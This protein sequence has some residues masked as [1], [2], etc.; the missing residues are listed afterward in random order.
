MG[1]SNFSTNQLLSA[2][3]KRAYS[4]YQAQTVDYQHLEAATTTT[5]FVS[6][7]REYSS[8]AL[9]AEEYSLNKQN[10]VESNYDPFLKSVGQTVWVDLLTDL[11]GENA[12]D[13]LG[14]QFSFSGDGTKL[15]VLAGTEISV[16]EF[17]ATSVE[18]STLSLP[19]TSTYAY[20]SGGADVITG[21]AESVNHV[22]AMLTRTVGGTTFASLQRF[23]STLTTAGVYYPDVWSGTQA[24]SV[25]CSSDG[26]RVA[27][28]FPDQGFRIY[29]YDSNGQLSPGYYVIDGTET[30]T[31]TVTV[32]SVG[33][34]RY[35]VDGVDR[36]TLTFKRGSV[37]VFDMS[38]E[39]NFGHPLAFS[40]AFDGASSSYTQGVVDNYGT[41]PP[42][43]PGSSVTFTVPSDAPSQLYYYCTVHGQNMGS[44][45]ASTVTSPLHGGAMSRNGLRVVTMDGTYDVPAAAPTQPTSLQRLAAVPRVNVQKVLCLTSDGNVMVAKMTGSLYVLVWTGVY[46][47]QTV[48]F[49]TNEVADITVDAKYV[50]IAGN[51]NITFFRFNDDGSYEQYG[52]ALTHGAQSVSLNQNGDRAIVGE[53]STGSSHVYVFENGR[54]LRMRNAALNIN[55]GCARVSNDGQKFVTASDYAIRISQGSTQVS[56][57]SSGWKR[58]GDTFPIAAE[59]LSLSD[60]GAYLI[61]GFTD[62]L[63]LDIDGEA[64]TTFRVYSFAGDQWSQHGPDMTYPGLRDSVVEMSPDGTRFAVS[65]AANDTVRVFNNAFAAEGR[66]KNI[67]ETLPVTLQKSTFGVS[68]DGSR[69]IVNDSV[70][71][72]LVE[73]TGGNFGD[74][75]HL[76]KSGDSLAVGDSETVSM[77]SLNSQGV[78]SQV[79]GR[80]LPTDSETFSG[81]ILRQ[82][83]A[84]AGATV[85]VN[86]AAGGVLNLSTTLAGTTE[87]T[88]L[89]YDSSA[90]TLTSTREIAVDDAE[91]T[92]FNTTGGV[93][94]SR[95]GARLVMYDDQAIK[96]YSNGPAWTLLRTITGNGHFVAL[97]PDG[98]LMAFNTSGN[99]E[100]ET[101]DTGT[102]SGLW[103]FPVTGVFAFRDNDTIADMQGRV[104]RIWNYN[105]SNWVQAS[106]TFQVGL[107]GP[108]Y[109][110][111][112]D[113]PSSFTRMAWSGDGTR[114]AA[115]DYGLINLYHDDQT[116]LSFPSF[117]FDQT[118]ITH[119]ANL[120][121]VSGDGTVK[122]IGTST[123]VQIFEK[124]TNW[125]STATYTVSGAATSID[126]SN[127]GTR[128]LVG[129]TS[130]MFVLT[131]ASGSWAQ[132]GS[133]VIGAVANVA[134]SGNGSVI[135]SDDGSA[136]KSF[137]LSSGTWVT[138]IADLT[139]LAGGRLIPSH[140]GTKI[141][142]SKS[143]ASGIFLRYLVTFPESSSPVQVG[144]TVTG[145]KQAVSGDGNFKIVGD[146]TDNASTGSVKIFQKSSGTWSATPNLTLTGSSVGDEFGR[147]VGISDDGS[148]AI[149]GST[150]ETVV[151]NVGTGQSRF[152]VTGNADI[153]QTSGD[154]SIT[155]IYSQGVMKSYVESLS[156]AGVYGAHR[157]DVIQTMTGIKAS[158]DGS[159]LAIS[160]PGDCKVLIDTPVTQ[161]YDFVPSGSTVTT[162]DEIAISG[163]ASVR[164]I[165][166]KTWSSSTGEVEIYEKD[167]NG[168]WL[169]SPT[170][171][172][173]GAATGEEFGRAL[174]IS[175]NGSRIV[176]G[177]ATKMMVVTNVSGS[178]AQLGSDIPGSVSLVAI[179]G[180]GTKIFSE[181]T[182]DLRSYQLVGGNW[183]K[184]VA[185]FEG[186][187]SDIYPLT[188]IVA[189]NDGDSLAL[190]KPDQNRIVKKVTYM[191]GSGSFFSQHGPTIIASKQAVSAE[192]KVIATSTSVEIYKNPTI[193]VPIPYEPRLNQTN[194]QVYTWPSTAAHTISEIATSV[195]ISANGSRVV[196]GTAT[197]M[198]VIEY[199]SSYFVQLGSDIIGATET[200]A[201]SKDG[202]KVMSSNG[203][204]SQLK[205][206]EY[207]SGSW[208]TY[209]PDLA[210]NATS[211]DTIIASTDGEII[212]FTSRGQTSHQV[213]SRQFLDLYQIDFVDS[214]SGMTEQAVSGDGLVKVVGDPSYS[215][216][217]GRIEIYEKVGVAWPTIPDATFQGASIDAGFGFSLAVSED[218]TRI[219]VSSYATGA[220]TPKVVVI[221][222]SGSTWQQL[223][224]D[225]TGI[226][227]SKVAISG[228]GA[229]VFA[230]SPDEYLLKSYE[231]SG[232]TTWVTYLGGITADSDFSKF[233]V[234]T[235]GD[236]VAVPQQYTNSRIYSKQ[237][238]TN[239]FSIDQDYHYNTS[240]GEGKLSGNGAV[241]VYANTSQNQIEIYEKTGGSWG[242]SPAYT[243]FLYDPRVDVSHDGLRVLAYDHIGMNGYT[244]VFEKA[245]GVWSQL[246]GLIQGDGP[247]PAA[248]ISGDGTKILRYSDFRNLVES[249]ELSGG[250]WVTYLDDF[251]ASGVDDLRPSL[252]GDIVGL[253]IQNASRVFSKQPFALTPGYSFSLTNSIHSSS[254]FQP[255]QVISGTGVVKI[256]G[257]P[258]D[259]FNGS[260]SGKVDIYRFSSGTWGLEQTIYGQSYDNLGRRLAI[261]KDGSRAVLGGGGRLHVVDYTAGGSPLWS[262]VGS[263]I[264]D[265][266]YSLSI[267]GDNTVVYTHDAGYLRSYEYTGG[268]WQTYAQS[269]PL[270]SYDAKFVA[271]Y[272]GDFVLYAPEAG[273]TRVLKFSLTNSYNTTSRNTS[274][275]VFETK[276]S[277]DGLYEVRGNPSYYSGGGNY[278]RIQIS[279][280]D[281]NVNYW[282][283]GTHNVY[284]NSNSENNLGASVDISENG[285]VVFAGANLVRVIEKVAGSWVQVGSDIAVSG[286]VSFMKVGISGDGT[287]IYFFNGDSGNPLLKS[288]EYT[289]GSWVQYA[290]DIALP[291]ITRI[292]ATTTGD[293][294]ALSKQGDNRVYEIQT[295]TAPAG[296][297]SP[298]LPSLLGQTPYLR[299]GQSVD[300]SSDGNRVIIADADNVRVFDLNS[301]TWSQVGSDISHLQPGYESY[302]VSISGD[303]QYIAISNP[304]ENYNAGSVRFYHYDSYASDW[305]RTFEYLYNIEGAYLGKSIA[306]SADG[307]WAAFSI[308]FTN[309]SMRFGDVRIYRRNGNVW[310]YYSY[311]SPYDTSLSQQYK[312]SFGECIAIS[313]DG[314]RVVIGD[315]LY[316][317][318]NSSGVVAVLERN[319]SGYYQ[320]VG[321]VIYGSGYSGFG[322]RVSISSDGNQIVASTNN[323]N[324]VRAYEY[325]SGTWS[326]LGNDIVGAS[327]ERK[328]C[329][330]VRFSGDGNFLVI[331]SVNTST[332]TDIFDMYEKVVSANAPGGYDWSLLKSTTESEYTLRQF[333]V[334]IS[335]GTGTGNYNVFVSAPEVSHLVGYSRVGKVDVH[336]YSTGGAVTTWSQRGVALPGENIDMTNDGTRV[337]GT[338]QVSGEGSYTWNSFYYVYDGQAGTSVPWMTSNTLE[339]SLSGD[340]TRAF[341][342]G[343]NDYHR[344][345]Q[346]SGTEWLNSSYVVEFSLGREK[347]SS[348]TDGSV[349]SSTRYGTEKIINITTTTYRDYNSSRGTFQTSAK[350]AHMTEDASRVVAV[351]TS[352][353]SYAWNGV[354]YVFDG[355]PLT[356]PLEAPWAG[357]GVVHYKGNYGRWQRIVISRDGTRVIAVFEKDSTYDQEVHFF[358]KI[359]H[360]GGVEW[361]DAGV[362]NPIVTSYHTKRDLSM[363]TDGDVFG[364]RQDSDVKVYD[365]IYTPGGFADRYLS[366]STATFAGRTMD[367]SDDGS[368]VVTTA[369]S[370]GY[371]AWNGSDYSGGTPAP[372]VANAD[373]GSPPHRVAISGDGTKVLACFESDSVRLYEKPS[374]TWTQAA[375]KILRIDASS[376]NVDHVCI[377]TTGDALSI[378]APTGGHTIYTVTSF[379]GDAY[380]SR[381]TLSTGRILDMDNAGNRIISLDGSFS[382]N[383]SAY[384]SD[385]GSVPWY[386]HAYTD[387]ALSGD[388]TR[389]IAS[390]SF[391]KI[392]F[393]YRSGSSW[394]TGVSDFSTSLSPTKIS[395]NTDGSFFGFVDNGAYFHDIE[396]V[397][398]AY[399]PRGSPIQAI[400]VID[401]SNDG[402]RVYTINEQFQWEDSQGW[403]YPPGPL[404]PW[405]TTETESRVVH[406]ERSYSDQ[407]VVIVSNTSNV[408]RFRAWRKPS[409]SS[410]WSEIATE[411][412][413]KTLASGTLND[414]SIAEPFGQDK[415]I[416]AVQHGSEVE[417]FDLYPYFTNS[418]SGYDT[419]PIES[420]PYTLPGPMID[421][422]PTN[423]GTLDHAVIAQHATFRYNGSSYTSSRPQ[424]WDPPAPWSSYDL[425]QIS[426]DGLRVAAI[427]SQ[428]V[429]KF[430][431]RSFLD[432]FNW[433]DLHVNTLSQGSSATELTMNTDGTI[434]GFWRT[435]A[436]NEAVFYDIVFTPTTPTYVVVYGSRGYETDNIIDFSSDGRTVVTESGMWKSEDADG[437]YSSVS[438][439][440]SNW[441]GS[442]FDEVAISGDGNKVVARSTA[443]ELHIWEYQTDSYVQTGIAPLTT[444]DPKSDLS[445]DNTGALVGFA[446]TGSV[447]FYSFSPVTVTRF[448]YVPADL[449]ITPLIPSNFTYEWDVSSREWKV[450][451]L[452]PA[453]FSVEIDFTNFSEEYITGGPGSFPWANHT[454]I[455]TSQDL[456]KVY[457][458]DS[459]GT[460]KRFTDHGGQNWTMNTLAGVTNPSSVSINT[461]GELLGI[462]DN[463][464]AKFYTFSSTQTPVG[465]SLH[466][467]VT[468]D[469]NS[470]DM[471]N[472][473]D[474]LAVGDT[475]V[476]VYDYA[477]GWSLRSEI[478]PGFG[479]SVSISSDGNRIAAAGTAGVV[480]RDWDGSDW[481][482]SVFRRDPQLP[483][484]AFVEYV[485]IPL[486][487]D[488]VSSMMMSYDGTGFGIRTGSSG[489]AKRI[490]I[491][492]VPGEVG[493][494]NRRNSILTLSTGGSPTSLRSSS[495]GNIIAFGWLDS[496]TVRV[497]VY[498]LTSQL[499]SEIS[500]A[501]GSFSIDLTNAGTR[502]A[503][504]AGHV[505]RVFEYS[506]GAWSQV[507]S[508]M[509]F[510]ADEGST[511]RI[512]GGNG[513]YVALGMNAPADPKPF[514]VLR[515]YKYDL[516]AGQTDWRLVSPTMTVAKTPANLFGSSFA[517]TD[518][519]SRL[520]HGSVND[521]AVEFSNFSGG[522]DAQFVQPSHEISG[523]RVV[524]DSANVA[525]VGSSTD[526]TIS[527]Y[528]VNN[529]LVTSFTTPQ[530]FLKTPTGDQLI[531]SKP[532]SITNDGSKIVTVAPIGDVIVY[533]NQGGGVWSQ[534]GNTIPVTGDRVSSVDITNDGQRIIVGTVTETTF[535]S[536]TGKAQVFDLANGAWAQVGTDITTQGWEHRFANVVAISDTGRVVVSGQGAYN[537]GQPVGTL[538]SY[539]LDTEV[540]DLTFQ[541]P[542]IQLIG[543]SYVKIA[544]GDVY[545]ELGATISTQASVVPELKI[546]GEVQNR[547]A[548][549]YFL[550]YDCEDLLRKRATAIFRQVDVMEELKAL[551]L[552]GERVVYHTKDTVY[553]DAGVEDI[554]ATGYHVAPDSLVA[555]PGA[556]FTPSVV[557]DWTVVWSD[558]RIDKHL[559]AGTTVTRTV[560]VRAR[561]VLTLSGGSS[562]FHQLN[563]PYTDPGVS[564]DVGTVT[565]TRPNVQETGVNV[566]TYTAVDEFGIE[567]LPVTRTVNVKERPSIVAAQASFYNIISDPISVQ[568]PTVITPEGYASDLTPF[569]Q[570]SNNININVR[571]EYTIKHTLVESDG[572]SA[573]PLN[574]QF[575]V[576]SHGSL[577]R[578][579]SGTVFALSRNGGDLAVFDTTL[580][581]YKVQGFAQYG[582]VTVPAPVTSIKFTPD[583]QYMV[584]GMSSHL[585]IGLV[586]VYRKNAVFA[587]GWEQ[588]GFDLFGTD[589]LGKFGESVDI[590][591]DATRIAIGAPEA[592]TAISKTGS[593]KIYDWTGFSWQQ[594]SFVI[595]G[596][597][598]SQFLG[599]S[600]SLDNE[601]VTLAVGS[602]GHSRTTVSG[603]T[604]TTINVGKA[605]VYK[606]VGSDWQLSGSE[607]EDGTEEKRNG[608]SVS[609]SRNGKT[610]VVGSVLGG[611]VRVYTLGVDWTG[612]HVPGSFGE[613]V[614]LSSDGSTFVAGS[615]DE[616]KGRVYKYA[617]G[618]GGWSRSTDTFDTVVAGEGSTTMLGKSVSLDGSGELLCVSSNAD[619]RIYG[620]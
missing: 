265:Y 297:A 44:S 132:L 128:V 406:I 51:S 436:L 68:G 345:W 542:T 392:D 80:I 454:Q 38:D 90:T 307:M 397:S 597:I 607:I 363:D 264:Y 445:I 304:N 377:N 247:I 548:G 512:S 15:A 402:S 95:N 115:G 221:E 4:R 422:T 536:T 9:L 133:D 462:I 455:R 355:D 255:R 546:S 126:V 503:V 472:D 357:V 296:F 69:L 594:S 77:F 267:S 453:Q 456:T 235:N 541:A 231:L 500:A 464:Q 475:G 320:S 89:T 306:I 110:Y 75:F 601:G 526:Q 584:V 82:S 421:M 71:E 260:Y 39:S 183:T 97:S 302:R 84:G 243:S 295:S 458:V 123:D 1:R 36:P 150:V 113:V 415:F 200:V 603:A 380:L 171:T 139:L 528:D 156:Y 217:T 511:I 85:D 379:A 118:G 375:E 469:N 369:G 404:A 96:V 598:P 553:V 522:G 418:F 434:I 609:L 372:W 452:T 325:A 573:I 214:Y 313:E 444:A 612:T 166:D 348:N 583:A 529:S 367:M 138:Y 45:A 323:S 204:G 107:N 101:T 618:L 608:T 40:Q 446:T 362:S 393:W 510:V 407:V 599:F 322:T 413:F 142:V 361:S 346:W 172:F 145:S 41:N 108:G 257:H 146:P 130:K 162:V 563:D 400:G 186:A 180:D 461:D 287:K 450:S 271:S 73:T 524:L 447:K 332:S 298:A 535:S 219:V 595:E 487:S 273:D 352:Q 484:G 18:T 386:G 580:K 65:G 21:I 136:V 427:N 545:T 463:G 321:S 124:T 489:F 613:S 199:T 46:W 399:A 301:S 227:A 449:T 560:R 236:I 430:W 581:T 275:N 309:R 57:I 340:G 479:S 159:M 43:T 561:P 339:V 390:E 37:Y 233:S 334:A 425:F 30:V 207:T 448:E 574:Q 311:I 567:A 364:F 182:L 147:T 544:H 587:G 25:F 577:L 60:D 508:P 549:T 223:G 534:D 424:P 488:P 279:E 251:Y 329:Y 28:S 266:P 270:Y 263:Y 48:S 125:P 490:A 87:I 468:T 284:A 319:S 195:D 538:Q 423:V 473:G 98:S 194:M 261:S 14:R 520:I 502:L 228:D 7:R 288:Y 120:Q 100:I 470:F 248:A 174:G 206:Y 366:R 496:G 433:S 111:S 170:A 409:G 431:Y 239:A 555:V 286:Q 240:S 331:G 532:F 203:P 347:I 177:G 86:A 215:S 188:R 24:P 530:S 201:I 193:Q 588:V 308:P 103:V 99:L 114:L 106:L 56:Q 181:D 64:T 477:S 412:P 179:S 498:D 22:V 258:D 370:D 283:Q 429:I 76:S 384:A 26:K 521:G 349:I 205:S 499:G 391:D 276:I 328:G 226:K 216:S 471:S 405:S 81:L 417:L 410:S 476:R 202:T 611:G 190:S 514:N 168:N 327:G 157:P 492:T 343:P 467:S 143:T 443:D 79:G 459:S 435:G 592:G 525:V 149:V 310:S 34:N 385:S 381:S 23:D 359:T 585:T 358:Y 249:Y 208:V 102:S 282:N 579:V 134:I 13:D 210:V 173:T 277:G 299:F 478:V 356:Q 316:S 17:D 105:G 572:I 324:Y 604:V 167:V 63:T 505:A 537:G 564:V 163:D 6:N 570:S 558:Q 596:T 411:L 576:G 72:N 351:G 403:I 220:A 497:R 50:V 494:T 619:V 335:R 314:S 127:D 602:P 568:A 29:E 437:N 506:S 292:S 54:W 547:V 237:A 519:G 365:V 398:Y 211:D 135:F 281:V 615:K 589:Y 225:I 312:T 383:G 606:L 245:S 119:T 387:I 432:N 61:V 474:T 517:L 144:S 533:E 485:N 439:S 614:S 229:Y 47:K 482:D 269:L 590:N 242:T 480:V 20:P 420:S 507:G 209:L 224:Q 59:S 416:I 112:I 330:D 569:L 504:L 344:L 373:V 378:F 140:N 559:R 591:S 617:L 256:I 67:L 250:S 10:L 543:N 155:Y 376:V 66:V 164:V 368:I 94:L 197:K 117:S 451:T 552:I 152:T 244:Y 31:F 610:L 42:G 593:V 441:F 27:L 121:A 605:S 185:N 131:N 91:F 151:F 158:L 280:Y 78:V 274:D 518:D 600:V 291:D 353:G 571:G 408:L 2:L 350:D 566:L 486:I 557:G 12:G 290:P 371:Y 394:L 74:T 254:S 550:R 428:G 516:I 303:G 374:S 465:W 419:F 354:D 160:D 540:V 388:G 317:G 457:A 586:R 154:G 32:K 232:G 501:G 165:G 268:A 33:G 19:V 531:E 481:N 189:S 109:L 230:Y 104:V 169:A 360:S 483:L 278:G 176:I 196:V 389:V 187:L 62:P 554:D 460:L 438:I 272:A 58:R 289:G 495:D 300:C 213:Y 253:S 16:Y 252:D 8:A 192:T 539:E 212:A 562:I 259:S 442:T 175:E 122:V 246:G 52:Q 513:E 326:A 153:V 35:H 491:R 616:H 305:Y 556:T 83:T 222:K 414:V 565:A 49:P 141:A 129:T 318:P 3:T 198:F 116:T 333:D 336:T 93:V 620:V 395:I 5:G 55:P 88:S 582:D 401:M 148:L 161:R 293:V 285:R 218:G 382:W 466:S 575:S 262:Q 396:Y 11:I 294:L 184:Y 178:W 338:A 515:V 551:A 523:S 53:Q 238:L 493:W 440:G 241:F 191:N 527:V 70:Y 342:S 337:V 341:T 92:G 315:N 509:Y 234:S 426:G 137:E 578:T